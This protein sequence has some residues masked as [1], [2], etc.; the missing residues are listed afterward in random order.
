MRH[1][2]STLAD[3]LEYSASVNRNRMVSDYVDGGC[4]YTF[5]QFKDKC[6]QLSGTLSTFGINADDK[7]AILSENMPN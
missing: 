3:V 6:D 4:R 1:R 2:F 5:A 7:I